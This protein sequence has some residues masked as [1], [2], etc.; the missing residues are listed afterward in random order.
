[1]H[2][3]FHAM[4][5]GNQNTDM[6]LC[7]NDG[8]LY[9]SM[10]NGENWN[11]F[12]NMPITQ[13]Y[14]IEVSES[15]PEVLL[16]GTQDN[17]TLTNQFDPEEYTPILGGDGFHVEVDP[18]DANYVY[19]EY[20]WGN[21]FRSEDGG[22]YMSYATPYLDETD[23]TNWNTPFIVSKENSEVLYYGSNRV[24]R[25][26]DR[27]VTWYP[28]SD[29][30]SDGPHPSGSLSYG[31]LTTLAASE[32]TDGVVYTGTDDGNVH[33]TFDNGAS[34]SNISNGLPDRYV[35]GLAIDPADDMT[36]YVTFSGYGFLDFNSHIFKTT[37]GGQNWV[38]IAGNLPAV[39]INDVLI[40]AN[41]FRLF[42]TTDVSVFF[43]DDDGLNW[44]ILGT[45]LPLLSMTHLQYH[46]GE[47]KIYTGTFGRSIFSYDLGQLPVVGIAEYDEELVSLYPNPA[48]DVLN[49]ES[50]YSIESYTIYNDKGQQVMTQRTPQARFVQI[51]VRT[52]PSGRYTI[53]TEGDAKERTQSFIKIH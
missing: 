30:L 27:A 31:T 25:S 48:Q 24:W 34:W 2:V 36:A 14:Q 23:R 28:I 16:G 17:N 29:D 20:Q 51:D 8:G 44:D 35:T 6:I 10:D 11:H 21:F 32:Q 12:Q 45:N 43:S 18:I 7:G 37:D 40:Q 1:M 5:F 42:I 3:D 22:L 26:D 33:V 15:A 38:G 50:K 49:L 46:E 19:A 4:E 41:P 53:V 39:P 47:N 9:I 52:L 13:F